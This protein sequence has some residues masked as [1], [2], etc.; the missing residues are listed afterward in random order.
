MSFLC[1]QQG[2][3]LL[4]SILLSPVL[5]ARAVGP[6]RQPLAKSQ[7][8]SSCEVS[9]FFPGCARCESTEACKGGK[10]GGWEQKVLPAPL[11]GS[12]R[13]VCLCKYHPG[14]YR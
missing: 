12:V 6:P 3:Y 11:R 9:V 5:P 10:R 2:G 4:I 13:L 7:S 14:Y 1:N 8:R